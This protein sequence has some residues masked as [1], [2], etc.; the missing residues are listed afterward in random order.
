ML[1]TDVAGRLEAQIAALNNRVQGAAEMSEL[2]RKNALPSSPKSA[3]VLPAGLTPRGEG[4]AAAG[5]FT[6]MLD[7]VISVVLVLPSSGDVT[8]RKALDP[9]DELVDQVIAAIAG[10]SPS[11]AIGVFRLSRGSL[12]SLTNGRILYQLDFSIQDQIRNLS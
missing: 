12:V 10:W 1:V 9:V 5:A 2:I 8:G 4:D 11:N 3:F 6:Q 7:E